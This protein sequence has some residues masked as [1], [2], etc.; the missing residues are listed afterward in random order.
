MKRST[1]RGVASVLAVLAASLGR[2]ARLVPNRVGVCRDFNGD[3][4]SRSLNSFEVNN[5]LEVAGHYPMIG[6]GS[7]LDA[8]PTTTA[9][10]F[11]NATL[12]LVVHTSVGGDRVRVR[13]S[14]AYGTQA[15]EVPPPMSPSELERRRSSRNRSRAHVQRCARHRDTASMPW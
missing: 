6:V 13:L 4:A 15:V 11:D 8:S 10:G 3:D 1:M 7:Y 2:S 9:A 14:N 5:A 12:R